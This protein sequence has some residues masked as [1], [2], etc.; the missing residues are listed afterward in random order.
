MNS[1]KTEFTE[2]SL[3]FCFILAALVLGLSFAIFYHI[4]LIVRQKLEARRMY[5]QERRTIESK[6]G[7]QVAKT[8]V[9]DQFA[10]IRERRTRGKLG[11]EIRRK[12]G[13]SSDIRDFQPNFSSLMKS[14]VT[15][16]KR[17]VF[18]STNM[19]LD[20]QEFQ[21]IFPREI[22]DTDSSCVTGEK[23]ESVN[24]ASQ[25]SLPSAAYHLV[26]V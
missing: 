26:S 11:L 2:W 20:C 16:Q 21:R 7:K 4:L 6:Q 9:V 24:S 23:I 17:V 19:Q 25:T 10:Q 12:A 15:A 8:N 3:L 14:H 1:K 22:L 13:F 5:I 18:K